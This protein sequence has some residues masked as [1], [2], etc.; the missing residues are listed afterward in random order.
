MTLT[1][2]EKVGGRFWRNYL[3]AIQLG[4]GEEGATR[5]AIDQ[6]GGVRAINLLGERNEPSGAGMETITRREVPDFASAM[7][8]L[9]ARLTRRIQDAHQGRGDIE[10]QDLRERLDLAERKLQNRPPTVGSNFVRQLQQAAQM[11]NAPIGPARGSALQGLAP[12]TVLAAGA[13]TSGA[14][15]LSY[16][17]GRVRLCLETGGILSQVTTIVCDGITEPLGP[18][19]GAVLPAAVFDADSFHQY[20]PFIKRIDQSISV[21]CI[22]TGA[23]SWQIYFLAAPAFNYRYTGGA[24][25]GCDDQ[26]NHPDASQDMELIAHAL[27]SAG[28]ITDRTAQQLNLRYT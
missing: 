23:G 26:P 8:M 28:L 1:E 12:Q 19:S 24:R 18:V 20:N 15:P 16:P 4:L 3:K 9:E 7:D 27:K 11:E 5:Y 10:L 2:A 25:C 21:S 14:S 13:T 22:A 17:L 6:G